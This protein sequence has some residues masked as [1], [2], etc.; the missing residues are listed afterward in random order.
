ML[1]APT[2][3][4]IYRPNIL[5]NYSTDI[6]HSL[7]MLVT[8]QKVKYSR[9]IYLAHRHGTYNAVYLKVVK[10]MEDPWESVL[11]KMGKIIGEQV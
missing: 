11:G 9:E 1:T 6:L 10:W 5:L 8:W 3:S 7:A 4:E 2:G